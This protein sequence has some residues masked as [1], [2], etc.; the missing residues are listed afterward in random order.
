MWQSHEIRFDVDHPT[1]PGHFPGN[2]I[3]PAAVLLEEVM[4]AIAAADGCPGDFM[5]R[6]AKF[7]GPV[8]PSDRLQ[9]RWQSLGNGQTKFECRLLDPERLTVTGLMVKQGSAD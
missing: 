5:I 2:P 6:S 1:A 8:R 9:I 4:R 7:L 3:I